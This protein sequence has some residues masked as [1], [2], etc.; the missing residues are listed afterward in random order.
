MA[1]HR[2]PAALL[3]AALVAA[4]PAAA[5]PF[6]L[7]LGLGDRETTYLDDLRD[8]ADRSRPCGGDA[9]T[10]RRLANVDYGLGIV[11]DDGLSAYVNGV[12]AKLLAA[13]PRPDCK[14]TVYVIPNNDLTTVATADGGILLPLG[15]L[16]ALETED[17]LAAILGHETSHIL[18]RHHESD[19][20][21]STQDEIL[22]GV[23]AAYGAASLFAGMTGRDLGKGV[24]AGREVADT[25]Y[26]VSEGVIGPAWTSEQ[27]DEADLLGAD[28]TEAAGY[29][30]T[31]MGRVMDLL[32]AYEEQMA[33]RA[34]MRERMQDDKFR[35]AMYGSLADPDV[36]G[37]A[38]SGDTLSLV[39]FG[40]R[41]VSGLVSL[42]DGDSHRPATER[43]E[44]VTEYIRKFHRKARRRKFAE[45][46]WRTATATGSTGTVLAH[47]EAASEARR[48]AFAGDLAAA[49]RQ[50]RTAVGGAAGGQGYPRL[51]F[52]EVRKLQ[53]NRDKAA[54]NLDIALGDR[55]APW[56]V[57][58]NRATIFT[59]AGRPND[60]IR[61]VETAN[62][63]HG[64][65]LGIV[66]FAISLYKETGQT[67]RVAALVDRCAREGS[68]AFLKSCK[69]AAGQ[70]EDAQAGGGSGGGPA[71]ADPVGGVLKGLFGN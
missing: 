4:A 69:A 67:A 27:E 16:R 32:A 42:V 44:Q 58:R 8:D 30:P 51:A 6:G 57:Y 45:T 59:E 14:V 13:T 35:N 18:L 15:L 38:A 56:T 10:A 2:V 11:Q 24:G 64:N 55:A 22:K 70:A 19:S 12:E 46:P 48:L 36:T 40:S 29:N 1:R 3:G 31:A 53:G 39:V 41:L 66:P 26:Q 68:R 71:P 34:A 60:A 54:Q 37:A 7:D 49:E 20:F 5:G 25:V 63:A 17:E 9:A 33:K 62:A 50:A 47:F 65:P 52:Y 21:V 43:K 23:D 28:I 61:L